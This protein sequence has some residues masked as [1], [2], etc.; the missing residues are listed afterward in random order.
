MAKYSQDTSGLQIDGVIP[1][2]V[3]GYIVTGLVL[4]IALFFGSMLLSTSNGVLTN[5]FN[6]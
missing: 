4:L 2:R 3:F 5:N 6:I 1:M